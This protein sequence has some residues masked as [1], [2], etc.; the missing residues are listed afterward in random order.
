[1]ALGKR[2]EKR[3]KELGWRQ[4]D[5]LAKV[6]TLTPQTLSNL[7]RRDSARSEADLA[8]ADALG[9]SVLELVYGIQMAAKLAGPSR[10]DQLPAKYQVSAL[11]DRARREIDEAI[12]LLESTD[13]DGRI[14]A[15]TAIRFALQGHVPREGNHAK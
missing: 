9:L 8:I 10:V 15:L 14:K 2:I 6:P 5:L 3:L 7:I 13:H 12:A 11:P 1:M 4:R